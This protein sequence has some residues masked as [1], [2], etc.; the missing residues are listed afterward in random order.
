MRQ[1]VGH[2][3]VLDG[4][5]AYRDTLGMPARLQAGDVRVMSASPWHF[6]Q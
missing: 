2:Q 1:M 6:L 5:I 4:G 3:Y